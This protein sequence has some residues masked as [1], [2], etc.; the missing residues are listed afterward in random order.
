M[1]IYM[2]NRLIVLLAVA[3]SWSFPA[4][5]K[6]VLTG[7]LTLY[8]N[9]STGNDSTGVGTSANPFKTPCGAWP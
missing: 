4:F 5:A 3:L 8:F 7:S 2:T 1:N 6:T 9:P